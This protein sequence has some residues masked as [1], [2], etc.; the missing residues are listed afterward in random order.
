MARSPRFTGYYRYYEKKPLSAQMADSQDLTGMGAFSNYSWMSRLIAG[1]ASRISRYREYDL[2]DQDVDISRAIDMIAEEMTGNMVGNDM[3]LELEF[4]EES[5][6]SGG[7]IVATLKAALKYWTKIHSWDTRLFP[8]ARQLIK[9]GDV[10]FKKTA[11]T[12]KWEYINPKN[13]VAAV[14]DEED[15]TSVQGWQIREDTKKYN[16]GRSAPNVMTGMS[17]QAEKTELVPADSIVWFSLN[18]DMSESAPFGESIL[19]SVYRAFKQ[20]ELLEEA[21]LIYRIQ[22]APERRVFYIDVGR[23]PPHKIKTYLEG[24]KNEIKQKRVPSFNGGQS[25][26][27]TVYNPH[28]MTEDFFLA[29]KPDGR[30]SR[31][32]TLPGGQGLGN[33]DD[34]NYFSN[35]VFRGI[36]VPESYMHQGT[37]GGGAVYNDGKVGI[38]YIQELKFATFV[39]RLQGYMDSVLDTEFKEFLRKCQIE[40][41]NTSF[42]IKLPAPSNFDGFRKN[43]VDGANLGV[44]AQADGVAYF[45]KRFVL[46]RFGQLTDDE[47]I[48]NERLLREEKGLHPMGGAKD[49]PLIYGGMN[50]EEGGL[51]GGGMPPM[52]GGGMPPDMGGD[53]SG[54]P[55]GGDMGGIPGADAGAAGGDIAGGAGQ[56][57]AGGAQNAPSPGAP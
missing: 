9:Y 43:E 3:P 51:M 8:T 5:D 20:K 26:I 50:T 24:F 13:V 48:E 32:E 7:A 1:S 14:V 45:S 21:L 10:Y 28:S 46:K 22:R 31:I 42:R 55:P 19:R 15:V 34:L 44:M 18:S 40:V 49:W 4:N 35:K 38:A 53:M 47:I 36:R 11:Y 57:G 33:L 17:Q 41:D 29:T 25:E 56:G 39:S 12:K 2:M 6:N 27:D 52:G 54:M 16:E 37:D 30:G 23:M